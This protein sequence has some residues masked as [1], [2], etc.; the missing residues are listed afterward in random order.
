MTVTHLT[1]AELEAGLE[2][3]VQS[4]KDGGR[5][6]MIV[7][8]PRID[9]RELLVEGQLNLQE[10]LAGDNWSVKGS[11]STADGL[12]QPDAQIT[13]MNA[14]VIALV[15][16][17]RE[18]WPL[19]GDQFYIDLDLSAENLPPG[20][21]LALGSAVV[22]VTALPHTG[23]RKFSARFGAHAMRFVNWSKDLHFRGINAK[24]VQAG[25]VRVGDLVR[26]QR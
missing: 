11:S 16:Q 22:E 23:C 10:G 19:A 13:I 9:E 26:I 3:I 4:P 6:E 1:M 20:T 25:I 12:A 7:R 24:V 5:V 15:A 18:R 2:H 21:R 17:E 14:R 8:R